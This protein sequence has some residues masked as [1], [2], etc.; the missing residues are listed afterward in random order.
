MRREVVNEALPDLDLHVIIYY[1]DYPGAAFSALY[2]NT[3]LRLYFCTQLGAS[4]SP[5]GAG[6]PHHSWHADSKDQDMLAQYLLD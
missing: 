3:I 5:H 6:H 4:S 2:L 1:K